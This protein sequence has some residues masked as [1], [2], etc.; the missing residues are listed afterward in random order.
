MPTSFCKN[1]TS[2]RKRSNFFFIVR[3]LKRRI[4]SKNRTLDCVVWLKSVL[5]KIVCV[6]GFFF[7][8]QQSTL[9]Q[10]YLLFIFYLLLS[11]FLHY[12][13]VLLLLLLLLLL[14][15]FFKAGFFF[16]RK[17][18]FLE[19]SNQAD[20]LVHPLCVLVPSTPSAKGRQ[21][22]LQQRETTYYLEMSP[23]P[24]S[25]A[26]FMAKGGKS[27]NCQKSRSFALYVNSVNNRWRFFKNTRQKQTNK[28]N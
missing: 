14:S 1:L 11:Y 25:C 9:F 8:R 22:S 2:D 15:F 20:T 26:S 23:V 13:F 16:S 5:F 18:P 4:S 21:V 7:F 6:L 27:N 19:V 3:S 28:Q 10:I 12:F 24:S 17:N